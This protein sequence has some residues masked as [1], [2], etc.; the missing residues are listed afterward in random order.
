MKTFYLKLRNSEILNLFVINL[1]YAIG[2]GFIPSG[3]IKLVN[4]PF[5]R[6]ENVGVFYDFLDAMYATGI[7]YNMIGFMQVFAGVL[8]ITQRFSTLGAGIFLPIIFNIAVLTL[9]TIGTLTPLIA[10]LMLLGVV[11]LLLWDQYKWINI[12][13]PDNRL[14]AIPE[15][16]DFPSFGKTHIY[17]GITLLVLP[18]VL[19]LLGLKEVILYAV[20]VILIG[21]NIISEIKNPVLRRCLKMSFLRPHSKEVEA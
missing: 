3:M 10:T 13:K 15:I 19:F 16:N 4:R 12:I 2:L 6:I 9:S 20:P 11:F 8:L 18:S 14:Y 5:T 7:Y 1:R 21:G 17:T